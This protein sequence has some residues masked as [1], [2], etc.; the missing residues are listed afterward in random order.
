MLEVAKRTVIYNDEA[1]WIFFALFF[2]ILIGISL[3]ISIITIVGQWQ[4]FKK[5]GKPGWVSIIPFYNRW[6]LYEI[7]GLNPLFSLFNIIGSIIVAVGNSINF[8]GQAIDDVFVVFIGVI[9]CLVSIVFNI[10][11]I[12][13]NIKGSLQLAKYFGKSD[14]Y[15]IGLVFLPF[16][17]YPMLGFDKK[18]KYKKK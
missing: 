1:F 13:F 16:V 7:M 4:V 18:A 12:V 11:A 15:G 3:I 10:I 2:I 6:S 5:A 17:F 8:F 14:A 9:I